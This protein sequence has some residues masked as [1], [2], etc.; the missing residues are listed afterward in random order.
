M[1]SRD[2]DTVYQD[3][4][5]PRRQDEGGLG[6]PLRHEQQGEGDE[7]D[8]GR[9]HVEDRAPS[10]HERGTG[11]GTG[12]RR[13]DAIPARLDAAARVAIAEGAARTISAE[14]VLSDIRARSTTP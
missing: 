1:R 12:R 6:E 10:E 8:Q 3:A 13:R 9:R 5:D 11:D 7:R 4:D 14:C 2:A